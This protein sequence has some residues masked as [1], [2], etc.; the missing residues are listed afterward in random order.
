MP[1]PKEEAWFAAKTYGYGWGLPLRWQGWAVMGGFI[2][3]LIAGS[4]LITLHPL[5][6]IG[7]VVVVSAV[8]YA[9]CVKK[10]ERAAWRWG[11]K[12]E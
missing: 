7:F 12:E 6:Y 3:A 8:L 4:W 11:G 1:L 9:I 2:L 10:G 5:L